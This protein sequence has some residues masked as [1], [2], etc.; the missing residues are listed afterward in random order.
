MNIINIYNMAVATS[1]AILIAG[2]VAAT[3]TAAAADT[4]NQASR[5]AAT[6]GESL[7][8]EERKRQTK[9]ESLIAAQEAK[10]QK[11]VAGRLKATA[12][13]RSGR[14]SLLSGSAAGVAP[15]GQLGSQ[16]TLG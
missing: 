11:A 2:A 15:T 10:S 3:G 4:A 9:Q 14:R 8:G 16:E 6:R 12:G 1:T 7:A 5:R 13:R